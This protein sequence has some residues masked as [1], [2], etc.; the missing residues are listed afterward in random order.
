MFDPS[1]TVRHGPPGWPQQVPPPDAQDVEDWRVEAVAWLL[2]QAPPEYR[3]YRTV[4]RHPVLLVW[5]VRHHVAAQREAVRRA[6]STARRDLAHRLPP[7][8]A[9]GVFDVLEREDLRLRRVARA[10][11]L[12]DQA[13]EGRRFVPRL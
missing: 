9:P 1:P 11:D 8:V 2:D 10:V 6:T 5:L 12:L 3:A 13:L 4:R 7:E